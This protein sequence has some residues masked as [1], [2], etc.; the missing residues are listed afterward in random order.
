[1]NISRPY[2]SDWII[3]ITIVSLNVEFKLCRSVRVSTIRKFASAQFRDSKRAVRVASRLHQLIARVTRPLFT[4]NRYCP[5]FIYSFLCP[6]TPTAI[7]YYYNSVRQRTRLSRSWNYSR[8]ATQV[9]YILK[10]KTYRR[11]RTGARA[12]LLKIYLRVGRRY[13]YKRRRESV[14]FTLSLSNNRALCLWTVAENYRACGVRRAILREIKMIPPVR[15]KCFSSFASLSSSLSS[16]WLNK[17]AILPHARLSL[18]VTIHPTA[19]RSLEKVVEFVKL[20]G[21]N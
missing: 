3:L 2:V 16:S 1:M 7:R 13:I 5:P 14:R 12:P 17:S 8:R 9:H 18:A 19:T 6:P 10:H 4:V 20:A 11:T 21:K 15:A